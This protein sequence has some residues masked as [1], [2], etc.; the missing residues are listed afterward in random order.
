MKGDFNRGVDV[1]KNAV[2]SA[3][4]FITG[5]PGR[6][7]GVGSSIASA[8]GDGF[9][10]AWN[11]VAGGINRAIPNSIPLPFGKSIDIAADPLPILHN[12]GI[13]PGRPGEEVLAVLEAGERV[14]SRADVASGTAGGSGMT[15]N[16]NYSGIPADRAIELAVARQRRDLAGMFGAAMVGAA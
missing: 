3:V 4:D 10:S 11:A 16:H 8:I 5:I 7:A 2:N 15:V 1:I 6:I 14:Y 13:V 9:K 12:G